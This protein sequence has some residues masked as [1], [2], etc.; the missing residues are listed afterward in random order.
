MC[1][2]DKNQAHSDLTFLEN[3]KRYTFDSKMNICQMYASRILR[4]SEITFT[5]TS[6]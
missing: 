1:T 6:R 2:E 4:Q 3:L 5:V